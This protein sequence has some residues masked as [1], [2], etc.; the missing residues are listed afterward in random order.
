MDNSFG[1]GGDPP[2]NARRAAWIGVIALLAALGVGHLVAAFVGVGASPYLAVGNTAVDLTPEPLKD[3]AIRTFGT[4]DKLVLIAGMAVVLLGLGVVAGLVSRR[5]PLPGL[6]ILGAAGV[7]G[8]AAVL[9]RPDLGQLGLLAPVASL[10]A[11]LAVFRLL[12]ARARTGEFD[13]ADSDAPNGET[14]EAWEGDSRRGFLKTSLVVV[15]GAGAAGIAGQLFGTRTDPEASR[16]AVGALRPARSAPRVPPGADF[17]ADGTPSFLTPNA[18]FYR[19]DT[20]LVVPRVRAED[21]ELRIHGMVERPLTLTYADLRSRPLVE[22]TITLACVSN[23]VGGPYISTADFIGVDLRDVLDEAGVLPG[24]EQLLSTSVDGFTAGT[25]VD[26]VL[27]PDRG[28]MLAL[29]MNGEP[30]PVEHGFPVRMVVP[31]LY[32]FVSATKWL[33]ELDVTTWA[34]RQAYWLPRGWAREAP[35]KT[36]SRIDA[37][38]S[39]DRVGRGSVVVAGIAWAPHTGIRRVEVSLDDGPWQVAELSEQ[40][41]TDAWRMWRAKIA[42]APGD[43]VL[44][45]R[46]TDATGSTQTPERAPVAP[47]GATGWHSVSFTG[48]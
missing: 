11:G 24:A 14:R 32:G 3:F 33:T 46:A 18:D 19:I 41:T 12:H 45:C 5:R 7:L 8:V 10:L 47:D 28:A 44:R 37:P 25:P 9:G 16:R 4:A 1:A 39:G 42:V 38:A 15:A 22:R 43:H 31:G 36:Q 48:V 27:E 2:L 35:I 40:V 30:L 23:P 26:V 34:A 21:W 13:S 20:A 29:G 6:V 17:V